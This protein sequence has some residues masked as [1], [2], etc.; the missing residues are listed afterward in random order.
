[1][2]L[3][4]EFEVLTK[5]I[6]DLERENINLEHDCLQY[7]VEDEGNTLIKQI[8][9]E[10]KEKHK[11]EQQLHSKNTKYVKTV[12]E[13]P[14]KEQTQDLFSKI[15]SL[16]RKIEAEE[17]KTKELE[18]QNELIHKEVSALEAEIEKKSK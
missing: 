17:K 13:K 2:K 8:D 11:L 14:I 7:F 15:E 3:S 16:V 10:L 6:E 18:E 12:L 5:V 4:E 1:M 9:S